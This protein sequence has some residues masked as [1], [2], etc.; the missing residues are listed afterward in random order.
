MIHAMKKVIV[1]VQ[2]PIP[3]RLLIVLERHLF[4]FPH[5]RSFE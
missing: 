2:G 5:T 3:F 4:L 1:A